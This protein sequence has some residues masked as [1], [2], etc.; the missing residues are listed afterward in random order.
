MSHRIPIP[1]RFYTQLLGAAAILIMTLLVLT[2]SQAHASSFCTGAKLK[3][4]QTCEF[5]IKTPVTSIKGIVTEGKGGI[6]VGVNGGFESCGENKAELLTF[7]EGRPSIY[8]V[9]GNTEAITV[10]GEYK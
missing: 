8:S 3:P 1:L 7:V 2:V 5:P 10:A 4:G 6:C 9:L